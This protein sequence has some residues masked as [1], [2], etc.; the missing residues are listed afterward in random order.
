MILVFFPSK[1][2]ITYFLCSSKCSFFNSF[3]L[4][5]FISWINLAQWLTLGTWQMSVMFLTWEVATLNSIA[6]RKLHFGNQSQLYS[7]VARQNGHRIV[8][9]STFLSC[10]DSI[11]CSD[12]PFFREYTGELCSDLP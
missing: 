11:I 8:W 12:L 9:T 4:V 6:L 5:Y 1:Q 10:E 2:H 7:Y 3:D